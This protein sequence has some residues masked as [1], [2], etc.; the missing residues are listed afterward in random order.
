MKS[1]PPHCIDGDRR[2]THPERDLADV[3]RLETVPS[4]SKVTLAQTVSERQDSQG[5]VAAPR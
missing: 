1:I 5:T 3:S 4:D 2:G